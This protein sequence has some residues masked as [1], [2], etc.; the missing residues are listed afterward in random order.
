VPVWPSAVVAGIRAANWVSVSQ[1]LAVYGVVLDTQGKPVADTPVQVKASARI[2]T[3]ARKRVVGGFYRYDNRSETKET[4]AW[5]ARRVPTHRAARVA[6]WRCRR[7]V[8]WNW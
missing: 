1:K 2:T 7:R 4:S 3:S 5:C 6:R 8:K